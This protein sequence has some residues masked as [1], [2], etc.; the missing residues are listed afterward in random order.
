MP[1]L[2]MPML[3]GVSA[4]FGILLTDNCEDP[5]DDRTVDEIELPMPDDVPIELPIP[6]EIDAFCVR[7][8]KALYNE[9]CRKVS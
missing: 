4:V 9:G 7:F 5:V 8:N 6:D 2:F 3:C 1:M